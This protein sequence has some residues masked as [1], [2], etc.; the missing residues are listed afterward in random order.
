MVEIEQK[1]NE[2]LQDVSEFYNKNPNGVVIIRGATATGKSKLSLLLT[3][4]IPSEIISADSRQ[5]FRYMNIWTDKVSPEIRKEIPHYQI[6]IIDPDQTYTAGQRKQDTQNYINQIQNNNKLPIVVGGTGLYIDTLYKNFS[7]PESAP[8][9]ELR[10]Q[11]EEKEQQEPGYLYKELMKID[12]EEAQ[13]MHPNS[14]R[15]L[16]RALEIF[17]TTGKTKTEGFFQQPVEQPIFLL[18][19]RREKDETNRKINAR[20]KQMFQEWLIE[21][22]DSLL[23][24]W[25]KPDLQ[26][27][28]GIWYKE[29]I[30][31]LQWEYN[32]E[33]VE[34]LLK[35]NTHHLAKKQ[36]TRFRRY[37]AEGKV[38]PKPKVTYKNYYLTD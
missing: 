7:L 37:I 5:I 19:L 6:D 18:W 32:K 31:Y 36:R 12:P 28:Q 8:N 30:G 1:Y 20:I 4:D 16:I 15:Y 3:K 34:E 11:L 22:V 13:K 2:I 27:M 14:L 9:W 38:S 17:Y 21:E 26:S 25:Y 23:K 29:I 24:Q 10:K 35:R 33:K